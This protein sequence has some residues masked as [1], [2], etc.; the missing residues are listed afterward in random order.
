MPDTVPPHRAHLLCVVAARPNLMKMAP[1]LAALGRLRPAVDVS[2]VHTGQHDDA[3]MD[4]RQFAALGLAPPQ[5]DLA[6][7]PASHA[8]QTAEVM[9]RFEPALRRLAPQAVLLVGDVNSTLAC[10]LVAAKLGVPVL[11]VEAGL[12]RTTCCSRASPPP[13]STTSATS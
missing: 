5:L 12:R 2:L 11:H 4:A 7:G 1:I 9:R 6:V 3:A 10:A 8:Q 13:A